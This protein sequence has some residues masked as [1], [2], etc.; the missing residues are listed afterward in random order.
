MVRSNLLSEE[1]SMR[2]EGRA[3]TIVS[4]PKLRVLCADDNRDAADSAGILLELYG[5]EVAVCYDA[6]AAFSTALRFKPDL[7]LIDLS[8]PGGGGCDLAVRLRGFSAGSPLCLIAV[9][10]YSSESAREA[11]R[12][13]GFDR[14]FVKPVDWDKLMVI[15]AEIERK[16]GR[17]GYISSRFAQFANTATRSEKSD[18]HE[19]D[20]FSNSC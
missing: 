19:A 8:M 14:H 12:Q 3:P 6:D 2:R 16:L 11:T 10:A 9:T 1:A 7:C 4:L 17:A 13:A 20:G 18:H 5:C 15:V